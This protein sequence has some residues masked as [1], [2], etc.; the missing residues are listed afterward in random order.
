MYK[1]AGQTGV[2]KVSGD[3]DPANNG[4]FYVYSDHASASLNT[5]LGSIAALSNT[6]G[7]RVGDVVHYYPYGEYRQ[8][9]TTEITDRGY[10]GHKHNES[11][12]LNYMNARFY[13]DTVWIFL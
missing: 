2:I 11:V 4:T 8:P 9:P 10:T 12:Q 5:S 13:L 1:I 3:P 7:T 6:G